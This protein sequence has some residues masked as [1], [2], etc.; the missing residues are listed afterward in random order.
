MQQNITFRNS[1]PSASS[2]KEGQIIF[3]RNVVP[4]VKEI[5]NLVKGMSDL[6]ND[7]G[8]G[9]IYYII[10]KVEP[11]SLLIVNK[12]KWRVKI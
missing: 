3:A 4:H 2:M 8:I 5:H 1:P 10:N 9:F 12:M 11:N 7:N 6:I